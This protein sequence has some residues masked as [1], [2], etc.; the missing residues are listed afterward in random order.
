MNTDRYRQQLLAMEQELLAR[1]KRVSAS[2][3]EPGDQSTSDAGDESVNN[4]RREEQL[5]KV[6]TDRTVLKQVQEA[7]GRIEDGTFGKCLVD[8]EPIEEKRLEAM[9][10]A[11]YCLEHQEE[12]EGPRRRATL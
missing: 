5:W 11:P 6:D 2:A 9:P 7:L 12:L 8:G 3:R 1:M 4:E 10:W